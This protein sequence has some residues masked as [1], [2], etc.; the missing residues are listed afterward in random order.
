VERSATPNWSL[1]YRCPQC[2]AP[3]HLDETA[4]LFQCPF[5]RVRIFFSPRDHFRY[6]LVPP[7]PLRSQVLYVPYWRLKGTIFSCEG[8]EIRA[9]YIDGTIR[10][11][12]HSALP[13]SLGVQPRALPLKFATPEM[14]GVLIREN[15]VADA[16]MAELEEAF[17][18]A[19][20][21]GVQGPVF[22]KAFIGDFSSIV[23]APVYEHETRLEDGITGTMMPL[24][25]SHGPLGALEENEQGAHAVR[26]I[27]ALCPGCG[28]NLSGEGDSEVVLCE[29]CNSAWTTNG[30]ALI[31]VPF[32][33]VRHG[34][35]GSLFLP[36]WRIR[37]R[38]HGIALA[39]HGDLLRF[40]NVPKV[41]GVRETEEGFF[42]WVP[43]FKVRGELLLRLS[44]LMTL[45][46]PKGA[47]EQELP[48]TY[49]YPVTLP[50]TEAK[51]LI[52]VLIAALAMAKKRIFP[53]LKDMTVEQKETALA[54]LPFERQGGEL[55]STLFPFSVNA[56]ALKYGRNL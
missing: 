21:L 1:E 52:S 22:L 13:P 8:A 28:W 14:E 19:S 11:L 51:E 47:E 15:L 27:P 34:R 56:N 17:T 41:V 44:R 48:K 29:N 6:L 38:V 7:G 2:G 40:A 9:F 20:G 4:R 32:M 55:V 30:A 5:C 12:D 37:A 24:D 35:E 26:F 39:S 50:E 43:A 42:F 16:A 45:A 53:L 3:A 36:F 49:V 25:G 46:Q 23:Y 54:F 31:K 10:A 33:V 18:I